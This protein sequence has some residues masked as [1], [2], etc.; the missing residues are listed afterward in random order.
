[1][2]FYPL[3]L[4]EM[5]EKGATHRGEIGF[6]DLTAAGATQTLNLA[7]IIAKQGIELRSIELVQDFISSDGTLISTSITIGDTGS[8]T[9]FLGATELNDAGTE[10]YL[11]PG[12]LNPA[13]MQVY[14]A[15]DTL[16]VFF[17]G[18][19]AKLLNT[20]TQGL[21]YVYVRVTRAHVVP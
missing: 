19:A 16:Q 20:H 2:K 7:N 21:L 15:A 10:I 9:R 18:T 17:T 5:T 3:S 4:E 6:A 14:T 13:S 8:A 1:M 12:A 11:K